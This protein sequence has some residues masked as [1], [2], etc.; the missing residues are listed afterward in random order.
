MH[1]TTEPPVYRIPLRDGGCRSA[2]ALLQ[3]HV[4]AL[5]GVRA[6]TITGDDTLVVV[7]DSGADLS[8]ALVAAVVR[9]GLDPV[10][11]SV[12]P[13]EHLVDA[14]PDYPSLEDWLVEPPRAP[15]RATPASITAE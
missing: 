5:E 12:M 14:E 13:L 2:R 8:D 1:E 4:T 9:A 15:R 6:A 3:L 7:A 10:L 11:V